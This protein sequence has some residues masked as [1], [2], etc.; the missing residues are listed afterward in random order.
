[1][2]SK[3]QWMSKRIVRWWLF[4]AFVM[5][6]LPV[7]VVASPEVVVESGAMKQVRTTVEQVLS[8]LRDKS[9]AAPEKRRERREL[10]M[11]RIK[12]AFDFVE[13]SSRALGRNWL[14]LSRDE[15]ISFVG[16]FTAVL[17]HN[18]ISK[19][20]AYS[21]EEV[22]FVNDELNEIVRTDPKTKER[23]TT[24]RSTVFTDILKNDHKI[25]IQYKLKKVDD[26]WLVY[27]VV[28]EGVSLVMNYRSQF[29]QIYD[30][31]K[32]VGLEERMK[33]QIR[34]SEESL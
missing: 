2:K 4:C 33:E 3:K 5:I 29:S 6:L 34:K 26:Q 15:R 8:I 10:I 23:V 27:D 30:K 9:L 21:N 1:M 28:V 19:L 17:Q 24:Y 18:Y 13:I 20:E 16:L 25:P 12:N 14:R 7:Q 11:A 22:L 32:Y 31:E